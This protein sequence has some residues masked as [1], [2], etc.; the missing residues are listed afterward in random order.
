MRKTKPPIAHRLQAAARAAVASEVALGC[1][2]E[3]A[4]P[5]RDLGMRRRAR[6]RDPSGRFR[7]PRDDSGVGRRPCKTNPPSAGRTER[8]NV[9]VQMQNE[10][11][12]SDR[13]A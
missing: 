9:D 10:P 6:S 5:T 8:V 4:P 12:D 3:E 13:A 2:P 11:T 7:S 1:H